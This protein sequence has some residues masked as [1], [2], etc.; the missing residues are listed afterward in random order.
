M[1]IKMTNNAF[2]ICSLFYSILLLIVYFN[3]ERIKTYETTMYSSLIVL[4]LLNVIFALSTYYIVKYLP[5]LYFLY[6]LIPKL[7]L[8]SYMAFLSVFTLYVIHISFSKKKKKQTEI[9]KKSSKYIL[10]FFLFSMFMILLLRLDYYVDGKI[11]YTYGPSANVVYIL[12]SLMVVFWLVCIIINYKN[13]KN[14]KY[15]PVFTYIFFIAFVALLQKINPALLLS[16]SVGTFVIFLMYHTIENPDVKMIKQLEVAKEQAVKANLAKSEFLSNMSHEIRTPL[17]AVMGF[18]NGLLDEDIQDSAKSDVK[19]IIMA[20]EN[21]LELVNGILDISKI[22][23]NKLEIIEMPYNFKDMFDELVLLTRA[24]LGEKPLEFKYSYDKNIPEY[25]YGDVTRLKQVIINLLTNAIKYTKT[26]YIMFKISGN[27]KEDKVKLLITVQDSGIGIKKDSID[28]LF[29]KFDRLGVEKETSVEGTGLGLAIT[30]KLVEL[31]HGSISVQSEYGS[32][33][34]FTIRVDQNILKG[35]ELEDAK[36]KKPVQTEQVIDAHGKKVLVV[37]DNLLNIKVAER[38]LAKYNVT[39]ECVM[40][41]Q[42]CLNKVNEGKYDLILLDD[43]MPK[44]TGGETFIKLKEIEGFNT[45]VV[46]LTANAITGMREK[47]LS[48]GFDDYLAK[49][50]EQLELNRV[51]KKYLS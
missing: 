2:T 44:M 48:D 10:M 13:I 31:M 46:I 23:A 35:K 42:E 1:V 20:S 21:L 9:L 43:M 11:V 37:D 39:L 51:I 12:T 38:L 27:V 25:L 15:Y 17:N 22:E 28:K 49:P 8:I 19:N 50:I 5:N 6:Y 40:S 29:S 24:R 33:S 26:G 45:P 3:R 4:N 34:K 32:G 14:K 47:Y 41:G 7:L 36:N 18:S 30:K 16:T